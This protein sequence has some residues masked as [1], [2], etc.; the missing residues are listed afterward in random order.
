VHPAR[1]KVL[2]VHTMQEALSQFDAGRCDAIAAETATL[3]QL[4]RRNRKLDGSELIPAD[5]PPL[6]WAIA[7]NKKMAGSDFERLLS[8]AVADWHKSGKLK[9]LEEEWLGRNT[10]WVLHQHEIYK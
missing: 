10:E 4:Q 7:V 8:G 1:L 5:V 9:A 2:P 3:V 6:P